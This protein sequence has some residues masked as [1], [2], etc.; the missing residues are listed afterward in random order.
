MVIQHWIA[1]YSR[2]ETCDHS[3]V[4]EHAFPILAVV[5]ILSIPPLHPPS[6]LLNQIQSMRQLQSRV[7]LQ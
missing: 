3:V 6:H 2:F 7:L 1:C 4:A 5:V